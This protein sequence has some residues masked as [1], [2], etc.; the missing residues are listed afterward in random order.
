MMKDFVSTPKSYVKSSRPN[1]FMAPSNFQ[2]AGKGVAL[3]SPDWYAKEWQCSSV[4]YRH[5]SQECSPLFR[6]NLLGNFSKTFPG[7]FIK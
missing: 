7:A 1:H 2:A 4:Y 3:H 5:Y 6:D